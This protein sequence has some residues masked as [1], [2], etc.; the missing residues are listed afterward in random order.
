MVMQFILSFIHLPVFYYIYK[1]IDV[2]PLDISPVGFCGSSPPLIATPFFN[3][4]TYFNLYL[5]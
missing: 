4:K 3:I 5:V 2:T 1:Y